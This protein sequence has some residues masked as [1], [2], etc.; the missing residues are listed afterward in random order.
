[1]NNEMYSFIGKLWSHIASKRRMQFGFLLILIL[2]SS[3]FEMISIGAVFPFLLVLSTPD[4]LFDYD[5]IKQFFLYFG[6]EDPRDTL[7]ITTLFFSCSVLLAGMFRLLLLYFVNFMSY[8]SCADIGVI[9]VNK[10]LKQPYSV[11]TTR[12]SSEL[13]N[14]VVVKVNTVLQSVVLPGLTLVSSVLTALGILVVLSIVSFKIS[15]TVC[16]ILGLVYSFFIKFTK[17]R[18]S[19]NSKNI[20]IKSTRVIKILQESFGGIRDVILDNAQNLHSQ[21]YKKAELEFRLAQASN[22]FIG[23]SPRFIIEPFGIILIAVIAYQ[24]TTSQSGSGIASVVPTLG[25]LALGF[26]RLLPILQQTYASIT[27]IRGSHASFA[28]V[29]FLLDQKIDDVEEDLYKPNEKLFFQNTLELKNISYR[30]AIGTPLV[31]KEINLEIQKGSSIGII[32]ET[33][34]GKSTLIDIIMSLLSPTQGSLEADGKK[35]D[36]DNLKC[37]R[38]FIS[39][40]PQSIFLI[41]STIA[42]N[43]ALNV[44]KENIDLKR[45]DKVI[46]Q[47]QLFK[48]IEDLPDKLE[49]MIGERGV[50]LSGGQRQRI[51]IARALYKESEVIVFDE[52]TSALDSKTERLIMNEIKKLEIK[53]TVIIVAH[54]HLTLENCDQIIEVKNGRLEFHGTYE[55]FKNI[56]N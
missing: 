4:V 25:A 56:K 39:H 42:E 22:S 8:V 43:I 28:D 17:K 9:A 37:W 50:R 13:I 2:L 40:V 35:I 32:G 10:T 49:T 44:L 31:L 34:S 20:A 53:P 47:A 55:H 51:G 23:A 41:D 21:I 33:G 48:F 16:I 27:S 36:K 15:M 38:S 1:M 30:Y 3:I 54:R 14:S 5:V 11:H 46:K 7:F 29:I 19:D 12:N 18:V 45:L 52:A 24:F 6:Y 26:Q